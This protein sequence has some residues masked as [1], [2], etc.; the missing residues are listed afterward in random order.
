MHTKTMEGLIGAGMNI[1]MMDVPI[2]VY[3]EARRK[4]DFATMERAMGYAEEFAG[5]AQDY[6]ATAEEGMKED[7]EEAREDAQAACE[8]TA[9]KRREEYE[10]LQERIEEGKEKNEAE[11]GG[12]SSITSD[13]ERGDILEISEEGKAILEEC[14][15]NMNAAT[16]NN[17]SSASVNNDAADKNTIYTSAG[18]IK[19]TGQAGAISVSV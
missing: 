15:K 13:I 17:S 11:D 3:K 10:K 6:Q 18:A 8:K 4:D 7:S 1:K 2:R 19:Q 12:S 14:K 5:K 9:Q 16:I